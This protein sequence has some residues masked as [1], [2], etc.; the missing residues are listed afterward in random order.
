MTPFDLVGATIGVPFGSTMHY[1]VLF[2]LDLFELSGLVTLLDLSP[3]QIILA[4]DNEDIDAGACWGSARE[5]MLEHS[6]RTLLTANDMANWGRPTFVVVA[7][8]RT[9]AREHAEFVTHFVAVLSRINDSF[10]DRLGIQDIQ[11]ALRWDAKPQ[12]FGAATSYMPSLVDALMIPD[13][14]FQNP[15]QTTINKLRG[16]LELFQHV[17][18][19]LQSSCNYLGA[20]VG[21]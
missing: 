1:Q 18:A 11:N 3:E 9:F 17:S 16:V 13:E 4:W 6:G 7:V 10:V 8:Q 20:G 19:P 12:V 2:L 21:S 5:H 15:S 14:T